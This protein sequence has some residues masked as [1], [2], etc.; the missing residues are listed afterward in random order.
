MLSTLPLRLTNYCLPGLLF[1]NLRYYLIVLII[2][3][4]FCS[5]SLSIA[6]LYINKL[7]TRLSTPFFL[8]VSVVHSPRL[9]VVSP[10]RNS[11]VTRRIRVCQLRFRW[12]LLALSLRI[13]RRFSALPS[14]ERSNILPNTLPLVN[15][16]VWAFS[17]K[18][19]SLYICIIS[20]RCQPR[21]RPQ[22]NDLSETIL[23]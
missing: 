18:N 5:R 17:E 3:S 23:S 2:F 15:A 19:I 9:C 22:H 14:C 7:S 6:D 8:P 11:Y 4:R 1:K 10:A 12:Y 20:H 21:F 13:S 16:F